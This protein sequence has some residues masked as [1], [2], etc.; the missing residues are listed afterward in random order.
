MAATPP[1]CLPSLKNSKHRF[2]E[3]RA[4]Y[5]AAAPSTPPPAKQGLI[6]ARKR[7]CSDTRHEMAPARSGRRQQPCDQPSAPGPAGS[8]EAT[9]C[10]DVAAPR[11][12]RPLEAF[13]ALDHEQSTW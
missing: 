9:G 8:S 2:P 13:E 5:W 12:N 1:L 10:I 3:R 7:C 6:V 4:E 11:I